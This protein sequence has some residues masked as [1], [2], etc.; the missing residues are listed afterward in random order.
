MS[1]VGSFALG[2]VPGLVLNKK[3]KGKGLQVNR[4]AGLQIEARG[5]QIESYQGRGKKK[6]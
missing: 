1:D 3:S 2:G 6:T 5:L 4:G